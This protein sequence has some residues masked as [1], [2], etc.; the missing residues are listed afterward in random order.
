MNQPDLVFNAYHQIG[1]I[2]IS[3]LGYFH[4]LDRVVTIDQFVTGQEFHRINRPATSRGTAREIAIAVH[5]ASIQE[6]TH[7]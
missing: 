6:A 7:D 5:A 2:K 1:D 3:T 4:A